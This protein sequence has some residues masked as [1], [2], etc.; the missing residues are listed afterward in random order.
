M[1]PV[2]RSLGRS[3]LR[4]AEEPHF[5]PQAVRRA[6]LA[7]E[8]QSRKSPAG[9]LSIRSDI[10]GLKVAEVRWMLSGLPSPG[11]YRIVVRPLRYR[12]K[13]SL[14]GLCEFDL[15]R[16]ILRVPEPFKPFDERVYHSA[17]RKPGPEMRFA[18]VSERVRFRTPRDVLRFLYC[19][20]WL[21]WYLREKEGRRSGAETACDRF[22]LRNFRRRQVTVED[23]RE[24]LRGCRMQ[25]LPDWYPLAA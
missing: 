10:P 18:W 7:L 5:D 24:A 12:T 19:H 11:D 1:P 17:R 9:R 23:A 8:R 14:S 25:M 4:L 21:H 22:A 2:R 6:V 15:G 3:A 13:P 16:I 20:E